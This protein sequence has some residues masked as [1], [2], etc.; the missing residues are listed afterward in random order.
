MALEVGYT[1]RNVA[2]ASSDFMALYK[3]FYLLTYLLNVERLRA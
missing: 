1:C 2:F 3:W